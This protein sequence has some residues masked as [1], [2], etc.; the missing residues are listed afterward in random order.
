MK[1]VADMASME[2]AARLPQ[3]SPHTP[4]I[5]FRKIGER[6]QSL[7]SLHAKNETKTVNQMHV[8]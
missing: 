8:C 4:S 7:Q 6:K 1:F 5:A 3:A 2:L